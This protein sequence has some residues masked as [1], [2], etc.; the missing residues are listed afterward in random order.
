MATLRRTEQ[1]VA[2]SLAQT[3]DPRDALARALRAIGEGLG[4]QLGTVW[5][6]V[7]DRSEALECVETWHVRGVE[8]EGFALTTVKDELP[9]QHVLIFTVR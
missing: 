8:A 7:S 1:D 9:W 3:A 2:R 6:P 4:W 5:E